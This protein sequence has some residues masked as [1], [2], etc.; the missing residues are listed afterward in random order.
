MRKHAAGFKAGSPQTLGLSACP[1]RVKIRAVSG[2]GRSDVFVT[3]NESGAAL[4]VRVTG[5]GV[6]GSAASLVAGS[7]DGAIGG[8]LV[9]GF[10]TGAAVAFNTRAVGVGRFVA[11]GEGSRVGAG[12][13]VRVGAISTVAVGRSVTV[14]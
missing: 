14:F 12:R 6:E 4:K 5:T 8:A 10:S 2:A 3:A 13:S 9:G 11:V 1:F 7:G